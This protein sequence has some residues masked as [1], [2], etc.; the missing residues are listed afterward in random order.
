VEASAPAIFAEPAP[1]QTAGLLKSKGLVLGLGGAAALLLICVLFVYQGV[2]RSRKSDPPAA[3]ATQVDSS[4]LALRVERTGNEILL[5]WNRESEAVR[6]AT[7][8][9]LVISDGAQQEPV[10]LDTAQLRGGR[11]VYSPATSDVTFRMEVSGQNGATVA[12]ESLRVL[13]TRPS[14]FPDGKAAPAASEAA[15]A[16]EPAAAEEGASGTEEQPATKRAQ[17]VKPFN[18]ASLSQRLRPAGPTDLPDAPVVASP[19]LPGAAPVTS[20]NLGTTA[21]PPPP[22]SQAQ[23]PAPPATTATPRP[24]SQVQQAELI[25]RVSPEYPKMARDAGVKGTVEVRAAV[26]TD[27]KV[28]SVEVLRGPTL[29]QRAAVEAVRQWVYRPTILNGRAVESETVITLKFGVN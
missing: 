12:S 2:M 23:A 13:G 19:S 15:A 21:L 10:K 8:A 25:H 5:T 3:A 14:P 24:A 11:I 16:T 20:L 6:N 29:L 1:A 7:Q 18:A 17:A 28:K 26:G 9:V 4:P 27:G 22:P